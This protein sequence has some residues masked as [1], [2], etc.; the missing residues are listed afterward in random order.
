MANKFKVVHII[1]L[2][3]LG[4]A[5][6]TALALVD[7]LDKTRFETSLLCGKGG[8]LDEE[9]KKAGAS[10]TF[11]PGLQRAIRPWWDL[12]AFVCLAIYLRRSR[13]DAV[14]THSSKAGVLGRCAAWVAGVPVIVHTVHGFGFN[15]TQPPL[16]RFI[17]VWLER[18]L[19]RVTHRLIFVS[20]ANREE[21]IVRRIGNPSTHSLIRAAVHLDKHLALVHSNQGPKDIPVLETDRLV[22]TV[23]PF[24]PQKNLLDF[25][26][27]AQIVLD[28]CK[29]VRFL[30]VGDG[31]GRTEMEAEIDRLQLSEKII[32]AGWR[33]DVPDLLALADVFCMTSLW[34]GLPMALV[35]AMAAGVPSVVNDVDGCKDVIQNGQTGFLIAPG[36]PEATADKIIYLLDHPDTAKE[37]GC[38]A[39]ES[40]GREFDLNDMVRRHDELYSSFSHC[41]RI[42]A[43]PKK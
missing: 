15:P 32:L 28:R 34:E 33:S 31:A 40:V 43:I 26:R 35:E 38:R 11:V 36:H 14:H 12:V 27:S 2:L 3:E 20:N 42:T 13:P 29:H 22:V 23:G 37:I 10:V 39:R 21:A 8:R 1:T 4:G 9:A 5:Q 41:G 19:A 17:F 30:V 25:I 6:R 24:K 18:L 16:V 7:K